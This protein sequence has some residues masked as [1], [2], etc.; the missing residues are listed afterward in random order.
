MNSEDYHP[1]V[2]PGFEKACEKYHEELS[3]DSLESIWEVLGI[4]RDFEKGSPRLKAA[5]K[6]SAFPAV[7]KI[8]K[9][10]IAEFKTRILKA[11][12]DCDKTYLGNLRKALNSP[13]HPKPEVTGP[14]A[15]IKAFDDLFFGKLLV[16]RDDWPTKQEVRRRAEEIL[17]QGG[18]SL[19]G[20]RQWP[21]IFKQAGLSELLSVTHG[22]AHKRK[23]S[24][25]K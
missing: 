7:R 3:D 8:Q 24:G 15:A 23:S 14:R 10:E 11:V 16:S 9:E 4:W 22:R 2:P 13:T 1:E 17:T 25:T 20:E 18:R 21:R 5:I 19:P 12:H 6:P